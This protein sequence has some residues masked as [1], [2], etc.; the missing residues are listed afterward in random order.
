MHIYVI[1]LIYLGKT[2][3]D[4]E[5]KTNLEMPDPPNEEEAQLF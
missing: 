5:D 4:R 3:N 1:D 2:L